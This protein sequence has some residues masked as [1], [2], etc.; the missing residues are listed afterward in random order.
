MRTHRDITVICPFCG[1]RRI[2]SRWHDDG[3]DWMGHARGSVKDWVVDNGCD[4]NLG[5]IV[6][7]KQQLKKMCLNCKY[8]E[9]TY[10]INQAKIDQL[11]GLFS[12]PVKLE[13]AN[14]EL[15]CELWEIQMEIFRELVN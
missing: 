10:C 8:R 7:E 5:R 14:Q 15:C 3:M 1:E 12:M 4:C 2:A 9:E 6:H 13:L 11:N